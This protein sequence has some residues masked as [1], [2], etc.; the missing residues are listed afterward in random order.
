MKV[1]ARGAGVIRV[2]GAAIIAPAMR[3][4][5]SLFYDI[6]GPRYHVRRRLADPARRMVL[7]PWWTD[8]SA[9]LHAHVDA[10][11]GARAVVAPDGTSY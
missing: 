6:R 11:A 4:S 9:S 7:P 8:V 5:E 1:V 2:T 10:L 3:Q